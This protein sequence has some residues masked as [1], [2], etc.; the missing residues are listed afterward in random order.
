MLMSEGY[1][2]LALPLSSCSTYP[3]SRAELALIGAMESV[4]MRKLTLPLTYHVV[5]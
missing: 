3:G 1:T 2:E 4:S 5:A